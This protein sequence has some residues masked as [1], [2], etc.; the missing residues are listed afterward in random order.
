M[1][2]VVAGLLVVSTV[3]GASAAALIT[4]RQ[5]KNGTVTGKDLRD[6]SLRP[7]DARAGAILPGPAGPQGPMGPTGLLPGVAGAPGS[8]GLGGYATVVS[9]DA[10]TVPKASSLM[11]TI[12]C[13]QG[14]SALGGGVSGEDAAS[15][16]SMVVTRSMPELTGTRITNWTVTL[17]NRSAA[18]IGVYL[19]AVCAPV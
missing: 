18:D 5:I 13:P 19:W 4:G 2:V 15:T 1:V 10:V 7:K 6:H 3:G 16:D 8:N 11:L 9:P 17:R 12:A 14:S